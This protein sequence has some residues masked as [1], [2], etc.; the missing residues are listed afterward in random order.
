MASTNTL[1]D[2]VDWARTYSD[3][4]PIIG[5]AGYS[6]EPALTICNNVMQEVLSPPHNWKWNREELATFITVDEQQDYTQTSVSNMQWLESC[7][8]E[9]EDSTDSIKAV[10]AIEV[11]QDLPKTSIN[12]LPDKLCILKESGS[13]TILRFWPIPGTFVERAYTVYQK[14]VPLKTALS[15]T[16]TPIP[17][18]L[19]WVYRIGFLAEAYRHAGKTNQARQEYQR[20]LVALQR[21]L[22]QADVEQQHEGFYPER[23]IMIG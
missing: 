8:L 14:K 18:E 20:F 4:V 22:Q 6:D 19:G 21:A 23:G 11:V 12:A 2:V 3:L 10:R 15:D 1:R 16:W 7:I 17:D 5:V 9:D 13:D